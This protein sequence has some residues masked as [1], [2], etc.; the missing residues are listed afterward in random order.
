LDW[1]WDLPPTG[2]LQREDEVQFLLVHHTAS[3]NV[4]PD[5]SVGQLRGFYAYHTGPEKGWP[6][7]AYNFLIDSGGQIWEGRAGSL[8][9]PVRADATGG[10]QGPALL[11]CFIGDHSATPPT[12]AATGAMTHLLAWLADVYAVSL[13]DGAQVTFTSRG[14]SLWPAGSTITTSTIAGHRDMSQTSCPGDACYALIPSVFRPGARD[15]VNEAR[16]AASPTPSESPTP[17]AS[18]PSESVSASNT[19][20]VSSTSTPSAT[21]STSAA[22]PKSA[23]DDATTWFGAVAGVAG[24]AVVAGLAWV[25]RRRMTASQPDGSAGQHRN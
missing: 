12:G 5:A 15:L 7:I 22:P 4:G 24:T 8:A 25:L 16:A 14:S 1:A 2:P 20:T 11:C 9:G 18:T 21:A 3:P 23:S 17:D 19:P 13:A 10:S 6:D